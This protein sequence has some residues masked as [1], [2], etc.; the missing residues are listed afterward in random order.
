MNQL[1]W[2]DFAWATMTLAAV[3]AV[4]AGGDW[5]T[6]PNRIKSFGLCLAALGA[7]CKSPPSINPPPK[8]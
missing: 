7:A 3:C 2:A 1:G 8:P 4:A 5:S 6:W